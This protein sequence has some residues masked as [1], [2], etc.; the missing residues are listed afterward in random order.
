M[1]NFLFLLAESLDKG[2]LVFITVTVEGYFKL[3]LQFLKV[4]ENVCSS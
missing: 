2:L 3:R 1:M 4:N